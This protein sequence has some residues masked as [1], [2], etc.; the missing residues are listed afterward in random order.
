MNKSDVITYEK[1]MMTLR[2][3]PKTYSDMMDKV[4]KI[5]RETRGYSVNQY[6]TDLIERDLKA[7]TPA[8][9]R[10]DILKRMAQK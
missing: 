9:K 2:L 6:L 8:E 4:Q 1:V 7:D 10:R 3:P 5:K